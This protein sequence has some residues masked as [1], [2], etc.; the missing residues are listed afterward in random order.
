MNLIS[1][2]VGVLIL[3]SII[4]CNQDDKPV[5][6]SETGLLKSQLE[7]LEQ[8]KHVEQGVQDAAE[9]QRQKIEKETQ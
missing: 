1:S 2:V 5:K 8:A 4:G 7:A 6:A 9:Q 3:V